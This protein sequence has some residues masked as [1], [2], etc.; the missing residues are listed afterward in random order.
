MPRIELRADGIECLDRPVQLGAGRRAS[1][2]V[3]EQ[4]V[5]ASYHDGADRAF[6]GFVVHWYIAFLNAPLEL[7]PVSGQLTD[8][9][10]F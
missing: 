3:A 9:V 8:G 6:C 2:R 4:P 7:A 10:T 1:G 5:L